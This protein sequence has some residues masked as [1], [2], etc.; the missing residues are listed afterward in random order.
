MAAG[1]W[2]VHPMFRSLH[3]WSP[4]RDFVVTGLPRSGTSLLSTLVSEPSDCF[5]FNEIHYNHQTLPIFFCHMRHR[6]RKGLSVP[7]KVD[8]SGGL[9]TDTMRR[10]SRVRR[11]VIRGKTDSLALG[12]N[13]NVPYLDAIDEILAYRYRV[14]TVVRDPVFTLASWSSVAAQSIPEAHVM[15]GDL[16]LRW[17]RFP[18][19]GDTRVERQAEIWEH[20][21]R[22]IWSL[23]G[24]A[25]TIRYEDLCADPA[26]TLDGACRHLGVGSASPTTAIPSRNI[27]TRYSGVQQIR[28]VVSRLCPTRVLFGY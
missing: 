8:E 19:S 20:Y 13:V 10:G 25:K 6:I 5:C 4:P 11:R 22:H 1:R 16:H 7:V 3:R 24:E 12:S 21:A 2:T 23:R 26:G 28:E 14:I 27:E 17:A 9:A 18:F 15:P